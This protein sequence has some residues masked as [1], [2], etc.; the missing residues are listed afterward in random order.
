MS[1]IEKESVKECVEAHNKD[2][3]GKQTQTPEDASPDAKMR[4][5]SMLDAI[6]SPPCR[7]VVVAG[8]HSS[9]SRI[10]RDQNVFLR[11]K[12]GKMDF[13]TELF[14]MVHRRRHRHGC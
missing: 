2:E 8:N 5:R 9:K 13:C 3:Y 7:N 4:A 1:V 12:M 11:E 14:V 6:D 10:N